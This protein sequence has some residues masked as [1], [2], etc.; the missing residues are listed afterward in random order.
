MTLIKRSFLAPRIQ[1][2]GKIKLGGKGAERKSADGKTWRLPVKFDHFEVTGRDRDGTTGNFVK[3]EAI[4]AAVGP[5]PTE[6]PGVLM[7]ERPDENFMSEM[8]IYQGRT[9]ALECDGETAK[10]LKTGEE[11]PCVSAAGGTCKC[12]PHAKLWLQLVDSPTVGGYHVFRTTSW[13][14]T[15]NI[16]SFLEWA[17]DTFGTC[18]G[19]PVK[20]RM[21]VAE[22][23]YAD[24]QG[25]AKTSRAPI[26]ALVLAANLE[27]VTKVLVAKNE[28]IQ[29]TRD[30]IRLLAAGVQEEQAQ[31]DEEE[32]ED[33]AEEF[34]PPEEVRASIETQETFDNLR[35]DL[36]VDEGGDGFFE[37]VDEDDDEEPV[38]A[39]A[40]APGDDEEADAGEEVVAQ[41]K[42]EVAAEEKPAE[43]KEKRIVAKLRALLDEARGLDVM[44]MD[45]EARA[46]AA[47]RDEDPAAIG[48][49][50]GDLAVKLREGKA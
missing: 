15:N 22:I 49:L 37:T 36:N 29:N 28:V 8:C 31:V 26:A 9:K 24:A 41:V 32:A 16:Q 39:E 46:E 30:R 17:F 6:L 34:H 21:Y 12:K 42:A 33:I 4:H 27:D 1:E 10:N 40:V 11:N 38:E 7:F 35:D 45:L 50:M 13:E 25:N 44:T 43:P 2:I 23:N 5:N 47:L 20:L 48:E 19:L 3:D 14:S 18:Y